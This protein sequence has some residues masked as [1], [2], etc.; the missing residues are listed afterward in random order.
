VV[1]A[2]PAA[3]LASATGALWATQ[4][5]AAD[6]A[7]V[8]A[9][10]I[11]SADDL[12]SGPFSAGIGGDQSYGIAATPINEY[13][14]EFVYVTND[15]SASTVSEYSVNASTGALTPLSPAFATV[16]P[17][18]G[19][20]PE[21]IAVDPTGSWAFTANPGSGS[22]TTLRINP[23]T[24]E[25]TPVAEDT[26]LDYPTGV[27]VDPSGHYL[28]LADYSA[29]DV[30]EFSIDL[31]TGAL[32][33]LGTATI[34]M[35]EAGGET[36]PAPIRIT[37]AEV[38]SSEYAFVTD[39]ANSQV[40]EFDIDTS[41]GEL[42][43]ATWTSPDGS[44]HGNNP[45]NT[46]PN[47]SAATE[48]GP[49]GLAANT[50]PYT[51]SSDDPYLYVAAGNV[52]EYDINQ[53]TG[54]L[55]SYTSVGDSG[56]ASDVAVAP[57]GNE[58]YVGNDASGNNYIS[59]Y[60]VAANGTLTADSTPTFTTGDQPSTLVAGPLPTSPTPPP[61]PIA[62]TLTALA[63]PNDCVTSDEWDST[64][65]ALGCNTAAAGPNNSMQA[66][67]QPTISPDGKDVYV[68]SFFGDLD[69]FSRD[70]SSGALTYIACAS[71]G[72]DCGAGNDNLAGM[73]NPQEMAL[74]ADGNNAYVVTAG[75]N[76]LVSFSRDPSTGVLTFMSC[77]SSAGGSGCSATAAPGLDDPYGVTVSPDGTSVYV[78]SGHD[79]SISEF[80]RNTTTGALTQLTGANNCITTDASYTHCG[81]DTGS[82]DMLN[83]LTVVVS[84]DGRNV[85]VAA[86]GL[87]PGGDVVEF[88]RNAATGALTQLTGSGSCITTSV[89]W[90]PNCGIT[91]AIGFDGGDEDLT[92]S[93]DGQNVYVN[94]FGDNGVI[95]LSRNSATGALTQLAPPNACYAD[96]E[97]TGTPACT[98]DQ[99]GSLF[100]TG[101]ALGV[102]VSPD[103]LN[104][105]VS[106]A[107]DNALAS[108]SRDPTTGALTPLPLPY[109]CIA[110]GPQYVAANCPVYNTNGLYSPR[111][112]L[113]SPDGT[114]V[115]VANQ[116]GDGMVE[117]G[118]TT[119]SADLAVSVGAPATAQ[120]GDAFTYTVTVTDH[121]PSAEYS[122]I[123][124]N[125]L[126]SGVTF[127]SVSA[128]QGSCSGTTM[129]SCN[130]GWMTN[131][132]SATIRVNVV[133]AAVGSAS[134]GANIAP[135]GDVSDPDPAN[136]NASAATVIN[137]PASAAPA[138]PVLEQSTDV[139]PVTGTVLVEAPG[140]SSFV[141]L[142]EAENIP[143]GSTI[144]ATNGTVQITVALPNGTTETGEFYDGE[145]VVTQ[146]A[147]GRVTSTLAGG[148]FTG[149][150]V[151]A[152]ARK[153]K[154]GGLAIAA[155]KANKKPTTVVRQ[156][157]GNAHGDFTTK[158]RYGSAA[159]SGTIWLTQDRCDGSYFKVTKD[160][161]V[162]T[163]FAQPK[164]KHKLKQGQHYLVLA[165]GF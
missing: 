66:S 149:C 47:G 153:H 16:D 116:G 144:N 155:A 89:T 125:A 120:L 162:V 164:K 107:A 135:A 69:E 123:L 70:P 122:P 10:T 33:P 77:L 42:S 37:T 102:A 151:P 111:R 53:S 15:A 106:G 39:S 95:E 64:S 160:T 142:S 124:S 86:G 17:N 97:L 85:Y 131:G 24:G 25:L 110:G 50:D 22:V 27:A 148:S 150:P 140:S 59:L 101:G 73:D 133:A 84:P 41:N 159:V 1:I 75:D 117:L 7:N 88:A 63:L 67:Y 104:V 44:G 156:L 52:D 8:Q 132:S 34:A 68:V 112:L 71:A 114:N 2:A 128:S 127:S 19:A 129:L 62:G 138:S 6:T 20:N 5:D 65:F 126:A 30:E 78:T 45:G 139:A 163:A 57:D 58:L 145:F 13:G 96:A 99:P 134:D 121:G 79:S 165:P 56:V 46:Y 161:I 51:N 152:K 100:G 74:S 157:W 43:Q 147:D 98:V 141:S 76:A 4:R 130:L 12:L 36:T 92:V 32:T 143:M 81:T 9:L 40:V 82:G 55:G 91:N 87:G 115:Y 119:P 158:G 38:G 48:G 80:A 108:F 72:S 105:Y 14:N 29:A 31:T 21:S 146:A 54:A 61:A 113:V 136:N 94:A 137:A 49:I 154:K 109:G 26:G 11:G 28:Y 23:A 18:A 118:R 3:A 90:Y 103:G 60:T 83:P 35:P 93:P